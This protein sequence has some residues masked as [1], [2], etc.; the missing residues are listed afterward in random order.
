M[1]QKF[2]NSDFSDDW[3]KFDDITQEE[4]IPDIDLLES[5]ADIVKGLSHSRSA[6]GSIKYD[7][8][9][10]VQI[11][12]LEACLSSLFTSTRGMS[13]DRVFGFFDEMTH[14]LKKFTAEKVRLS[15]ARM[16]DLAVGETELPVFTT[17]DLHQISQVWFN[18]DV[19]NPDA[20]KEKCR[21]WDI[22]LPGKQQMDGRGFSN[23]EE[24]LSQDC[25][26]T[27]LL[28][29]LS[30]FFEKVNLIIVGLRNLVGSVVRRV[31]GQGDLLNEVATVGQ[32]QGLQRVIRTL[33]QGLFK[34]LEGTRRNRRTHS[35]KA[36]NSQQKPGF[37]R[38]YQH[39]GNWTL[40]DD[41][42]HAKGCKKPK[43]DQLKQF[44]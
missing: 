35:S 22:I 3:S 1:E 31:D 44:K 38:F 40:V 15:D 32:I 29:G 20:K 42:N 10:A 28:P 12:E 5:H 4:M 19:K 9:E 36:D 16:A 8:F 23:S 21:T 17:G 7:P 41:K 26:I 37:K 33:N 18:P 14:F 6:R 13:I 25:P 27:L 11:S 2:D 30:D 34:F 24:I 39:L 43:T